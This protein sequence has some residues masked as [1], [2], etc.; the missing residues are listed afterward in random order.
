MG[1][2]FGNLVKMYDNLVPTSN[3]FRVNKRIYMMRAKNTYH[4]PVG[5][6]AICYECITWEFEEGG[7][8]QDPY[9][10]EDLPWQDDGPSPPANDLFANPATITGASGTVVIPQFDVDRA[11][12]EAGEPHVSSGWHSLWYQWTSPITGT[13]TF[14]TLSG[15]A[16]VDTELTAYTGSVLGSLTEHAHNDDTTGTLSSISFAVASG[17]TYKIQ[18]VNRGNALGSITLNWNAV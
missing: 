3:R 9:E 11:W 2:A 17:T 7:V 15:D 16:S 14:D 18:V 1:P 4:V 12:R 5:E 13:A 6:D 10:V 8:G